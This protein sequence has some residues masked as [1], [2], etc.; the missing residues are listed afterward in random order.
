M[1]SLSK[2]VVGEWSIQLLRH[3]VRSPTAMTQLMR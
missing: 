2:P 1:R 3:L